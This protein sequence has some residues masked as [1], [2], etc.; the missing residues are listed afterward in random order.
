MADDSAVVSLNDTQVDERLN[1][2]ERPVV[3]LDRKTKVLRGKVVGLV[4][5]QRQH[6]KASEW[7]WEPEDEMRKHY[8]RLFVA[9]DFKDEI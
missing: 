7:T 5:V 4:N 6:R 3:N 9:L 2:M 8:P 1:Y